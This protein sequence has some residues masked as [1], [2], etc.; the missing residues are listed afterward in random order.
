MSDAPPK[1]PSEP[2]KSPKKYR[3]RSDSEQKGSESEF[4]MQ[5]PNRN[6]VDPDTPP[7]T[8][9]DEEEEEDEGAEEERGRKT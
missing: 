3:P 6:V 7:N 5:N 4:I 8:Q 1:K 2:S 9:D